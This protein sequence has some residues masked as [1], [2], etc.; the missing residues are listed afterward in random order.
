LPTAAAGIT[1][2]DHDRVLVLRVN[3][4]MSNSRLSLLAGLSSAAALG[5]SPARIA[6]AGVSFLARPVPAHV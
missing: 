6:A 2:A 1:K 5:H 3:L 4:R